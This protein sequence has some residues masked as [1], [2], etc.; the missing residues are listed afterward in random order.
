MQ[1]WD[2]AQTGLYVP[3]WDPMPTAPTSRCRG[4]ISSPALSAAAGTYKTVRAMEGLRN[5]PSASGIDKVYFEIDSRL[6]WPAHAA[7]GLVK[8]TVGVTADILDHADAW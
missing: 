8:S 6:E 1:S 4:P 7:V 2:L 3:G 5:G